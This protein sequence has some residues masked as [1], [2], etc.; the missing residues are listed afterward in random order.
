MIFN[1]SRNEVRSFLISNALFWLDK[2]HLDGLWVDAVVSMLY[3]DYSRREGQWIPNCYGGRENLAAISLLQKVNE[4][5]H[6]VFPG[7]LTIAEESTAWPMV[8]RPTTFGGLG[9]SL[10]WNMGWMHDTLGLNLRKNFLMLI[11]QIFLML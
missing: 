6:G 8:S 1:Y 9:F 2:Y 5:V 4:V 10:K 11:D 3:L 7:I